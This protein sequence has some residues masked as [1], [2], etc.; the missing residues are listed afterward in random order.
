MSEAHRPLIT[1][2]IPVFNGDR[3]LDACLR[4]VAAQ[5]FRNFEVLVIDDCSS[6]RSLDLAHAFAAV[7]ERVRVVRNPRNLGLVGNWNRCVQL[8]MGEWIKFVF[9]DDTIDPDC[10]ERLSEVAW[11]ARPL[12]ACRRR[13]EFAPDTTTEMREF[14]AYHKALVDAH[15]ARTDYLSPEECQ[16]FAIARIGENLLG[17]PT[18]TMIHRSA[19]DRY[20]TFNPALIHRCDSE[21][22]IRVA[23]NAG[24][25]LVPQELATFRVH[26]AAASAHNRRER[27]FRML[28]LDRLIILHD[29]LFRREYAPVRS[30]AATS[31]PSTDLH[32]LFEHRR[33]EAAVQF[34]QLRGERRDINAADE[35]STLLDTYPALAPS[36]LSH[37]VWRLRQRVRSSRRARRSVEAGRHSA[38]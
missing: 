2:C 16:A 28:T 29:Y 7:H 38:G 13:F 18:C 35:W 15:F 30:L 4:S 14:Y 27:A 31:T 1:V 32:W 12:M 33:H 5:T 37:A 23:V 11:P 36:R 26:G 25:A 6:D 22:W 9:Q 8:A 21:Y 34:Q 20:G 3:Y 19:F 17:E 24:A 10:L